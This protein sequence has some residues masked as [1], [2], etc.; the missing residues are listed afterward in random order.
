MMRILLTIHHE[1]DPDSGAPGATLALADA[2]R[3]QGHDVQV[4]SHDHLPAWA[5]GRRALFLF[6]MLVAWRAFRGRH[7]WDVVDFSSYDGWIATF[8]PRSFRPRLLAFHSHGL[9][10]IAHEQRVADARRGKQGLSLK[11]FLYR[12]S[13]HLW[14]VGRAARRAEIAFFLNRNEQQYAVRDLGV[15]M[16]K[17]ALAV[18][19][20]S[21]AFLAAAQ[22]PKRCPTEREPLNVAFIGG[23]I[24][25]KGIAYLMPALATYLQRHPTAHALLAGT[26]VIPDKVLADVPSQLRDRVKVIPTFDRG[27]LPS[28]LADSQV[29]VLPSLSEGFN[30]AALE[31]M[32]CGLVPILTRG[33]GFEEY[34][35]DGENGILIDRGSSEQIVRALERL[36]GD[37]A[38]WRRMSDEAIR[39]ARTFTWAKAA[40]TQ[41]GG[42][43]HAPRPNGRWLLDAPGDAS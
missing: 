12:G 7:R 43:E 1:L 41:I 29:F 20:L 18:N 6:P 21:E 19:G 31:A 34:T 24:Q 5:R 22:I 9:E 39:V 33:Y 11:Y 28:L 10:H 23:Y 30:I 38:A 16:S 2:M 40:S 13:L 25:I 36:N 14:A 4:L 35:T 42:Y 3:D 37:R 17:S 27:Q 26:R 8:L 32:A 15:E